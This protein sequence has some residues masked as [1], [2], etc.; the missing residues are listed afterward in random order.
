[1]LV[2][3]HRVNNPCVFGQDLVHWFKK[4]LSQYDPIVYFGV[5]YY[6]VNKNSSS[7]ACDRTKGCF[8]NLYS[9]LVCA[10]SINTG[11]NLKC[12]STCLNVKAIELPK[13][14]V[15]VCLWNFSDGKQVR[16]PSFN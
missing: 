8:S 5:Y 14:F 6:N 4:L 13:K 3:I 16:L 11:V 10:K 2:P 12:H 7:D 1:M 9:N 15:V